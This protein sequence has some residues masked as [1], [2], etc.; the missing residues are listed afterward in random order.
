MTVTQI[1]IAFW[2]SGWAISVLVYL[3]SSMQRARKTGL[4]WSPTAYLTSA[5][6]LLFTWLISWVVYIYAWIKH[7]S[8]SS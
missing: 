2:L 8:Y 5:A 6:A 1:I 4:P 3:W 7:R